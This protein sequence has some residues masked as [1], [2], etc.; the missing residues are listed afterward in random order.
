ME[1]EKKKGKLPPWL[2]RRIGCGDTFDHTSSA[3]SDLGVET[4]CNHANCPNKGECWSRGTATVLILGGTCTRNCKFC[5]VAPGKPLPPDPTEPMRVAKLA[6][7][8]KL[9]YIVITSVTRDDLPDGGAAHFRD[10]VLE[11]KKAVPGIEIE[12]LVP[13]FK[14]CQ[15]Q[16]IEILA[17]AMPFVFGHNI[18]TV[19]EMF[20]V[21]R[22]GGDYQRSLDLLKMVKEQYPDIPTKSS[23]MLG[24]GEN[25]AQILQTL[26]DLRAN[27]VDRVAL[28]QYLKSEAEAVEVA[29][30]VT[31]EKFEFWDTVARDM[32][33]KWV[34]SSPYT[35]S[36]YHAETETGKV[37]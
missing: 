9:K 23:M 6:A 33:F 27:G 37:E 13:D 22:S 32:G 31:P 16:A 21:V 5:S 17:E 2:R 30:Y 15:Q 26:K 28:G 35:R 19:S 12:L 25:D 11:T 8:M 3:L 7:E 24:I 14:G 18:E 10:T 4:I 36:S 1:Q 20:P 34:M 29:E